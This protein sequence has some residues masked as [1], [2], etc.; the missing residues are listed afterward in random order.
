MELDH[1]EHPYEP[2][3]HEVVI[4]THGLRKFCRP[5]RTDSLGQQVGEVARELGV[6]PQAVLDARWAGRFTEK[7][8]KG[9]GGKHGPPVP[10]IHSWT[11]LDPGGTGHFAKPDA[12]WGALWEFLPDMIA[13]GFEQTVVRRP[14]F[15]TWGAWRGK[16][17][18][19][20]N[21]CPTGEEYKD[22]LK[23][24]GWRW[25]CPGC[26]KE[27]RKIYCPLPVTTLFDSL[28]Y[29]P[30]VYRGRAGGAPQRFL[31]YD[32][33]KV[34]APPATFACAACHG[35]EWFTRTN[36]RA[37]NCVV[38]HLTRGMLYGREVPVP[39]WYRRE[40]KK[41]RC[42]K[43][44][45]PAVKREGVFVRMMNGWT[46]EQIAKEMLISK[47][48]VEWMVRFICRQ[49]GVKNRAQLA[50]KLGWKHEQ[51]LNGR[52]KLLAKAKEREEAVLGMVLEGIRFKEIARRVGISI[53]S[54]EQ[55]ASGIYRRHGLAKGEGRRGLKKLQ[56]IGG[57]EA[58]RS[59]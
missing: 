36:A 20:R 32:V 14:V 6:S 1:P 10:L 31:R 16:R 39:Q 53:F 45:R 42:R 49:E 44:G 9:L 3:E 8:I 35:V 51:P 56:E 13:D 40:R 55:M 11:A 57:I 18:A 52:E 22:D 47:R 38:S 19:D 30:A 50:A 27:V 4:G 48:S 24:R 41:A 2:I 25:V 7:L 46:V 54:V 5:V 34:E 23:F 28:G 59:A 43:L 17:M 33:E 58:Q 21:V 12:L 37:W 15:S 26:K 29:D